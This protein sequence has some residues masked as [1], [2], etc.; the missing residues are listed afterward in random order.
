MSSVKL[1]SS[2]GGS[3]SLSAAST[4][5]DVTIKFP[6]GNSSIGQALVAG[7]TSGELDWEDVPTDS[8]KVLYQGFLTPGSGYLTSVL[9]DGGGTILNP[10]TLPF[11][12]ISV[13]ELIEV[14][15]THTGYDYTNHYYVIPTS[16]YY[17]FTLNLGV[18]PN[19]NHATTQ[20]LFSSIITATDS[21]NTELRSFISNVEIDNTNA[22]ARNCYV[23]GV[24]KMYANYRVYFGYSALSD[25]SGN[26]DS[27]L[28]AVVNY[29]HPVSCA[30]IERIRGL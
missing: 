5:T 13:P 4:S 11:D 1:S 12:Y 6:S 15:D 24:M 28:G 19:S 29:I 27:I 8:S 30:T 22:L 21:T 23:D 14:I 2:G 9:A 16:G 18:V 7:N 3:V 10:T 20:R 26:H 17:R 25:S